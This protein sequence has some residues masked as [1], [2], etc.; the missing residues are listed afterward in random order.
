[1]CEI[2]VAA[3]IRRSD[4]CQ[5]YERKEREREREPFFGAKPCIVPQPNRFVRCVLSVDIHSR[6]YPDLNKDDFE[7]ALRQI[8]EL[9]EPLD[10][11]L[12]CRKGCIVGRRK[13]ST[14]WNRTMQ[15]R[16]TRPI[17]L[18]RD[19]NASHQLHAGGR[20]ENK[21]SCCPVGRNACQI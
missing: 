18:N 3:T 7:Y 1:M 6:K 19:N 12:L 4:P 8:A 10:I 14:V 16:C 15:P 5:V 2:L 21:E 13:P 9:G 17:T 11:T 20:E